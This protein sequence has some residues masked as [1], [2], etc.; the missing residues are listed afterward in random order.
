MLLYFPAE[1]DHRIF[2]SDFFNNL[3]QRLSATKSRKYTFVNNKDKLIVLVNLDSEDEE[4]R[5]EEIRKMMED[6]LFGGS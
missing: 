1:K 3:V 2:K 4:K 6:L 5:I